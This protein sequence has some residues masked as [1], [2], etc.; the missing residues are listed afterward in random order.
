MLTETTLVDVTISSS[1][2]AVTVRELKSVQMEV[3][4]E[5]SVL[6][7]VISMLILTATVEF[8]ITALAVDGRLY[9]S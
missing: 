8:V 2:D 1:G 5:L 3:S 9:P 6:R 7:L 4:P